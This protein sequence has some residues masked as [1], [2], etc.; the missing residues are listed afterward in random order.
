MFV[1]WLG[2]CFGLWTCIVLFILLVL[3]VCLGDALRE[4]CCCI[5]WMVMVVV[6]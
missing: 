6:V 2:A 3:L 5:G 1:D 4:W